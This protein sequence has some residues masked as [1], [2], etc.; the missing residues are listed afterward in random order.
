MDKI[1]NCVKNVTLVCV[2]FI[3]YSMSLKLLC[4][5][6]SL[7]T[8]VVGCLFAQISTFQFGRSTCMNIRILLLLIIWNMAGQ[9]GLKVIAVSSCQTGRNHRWA[10]EFPD[11][12]VN[13]LQKEFK[14]GTV[15]GPFKFNSFSVNM[16]LPPLNS[17]AKK[18]STDRCVILDLSY[19]V[20]SSV[21]DFILSDSF[22]G[23]SLSLHYPSIDNLVSLVKVKG[24]R[25]L[26]V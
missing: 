17:V 13:Y 4:L 21:I 10:K 9:L 15:I 18:E 12:M 25:L 5:Q 3:M 14:E 22:L 20:W 16:V 7:I 11:Q 2:V 1:V 6:V 26:F 19:P 8:R 24:K 23:E